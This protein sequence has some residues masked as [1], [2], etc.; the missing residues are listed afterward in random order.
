MI[1]IM[2]GYGY[3]NKRGVSLFEWGYNIRI[4]LFKLLK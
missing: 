2:R 1:G 3:R 4:E